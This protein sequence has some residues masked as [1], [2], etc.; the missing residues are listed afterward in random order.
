VEFKSPEDTL[1]IADFHKVIAYAHLYCALS[2]KV[3]ISD[4]TVS[5]VVTKHPRRLFE[6]LREEYH[7]EI[8]EVRPGIY[9][10]GGDRPGIQLIESRKLS[11]GGN[12]W[13]RNIGRGLD[14][15][16][17][18]MVLRAREEIPEGV[19]IG[20]YMFLKANY[21]CVLEEV[22][23]S[24]AATFEAFL[25][26]SGLPALWKA[27]GKAI[28]EAIGEEKRAR[29]VAQ[30]FLRKGLAVEDVAEATELPLEMVRKLKN[31]IL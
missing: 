13:I 12:V 2:G 20:A 1:S 11:G 25:K 6:Y 5:F 24:E 31:S 4:V 21:E 26:E 17:V 3:K 15:E 8:Q 18:R 22:K 16:E 27:E 28:G 23:M 14:R 7:E 29:R 10:L 9:R 19:P 30:N